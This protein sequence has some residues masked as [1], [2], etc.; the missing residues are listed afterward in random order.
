MEEIDH[1]TLIRATRQAKQLVGRIKLNLNKLD[2][3]NKWADRAYKN[4]ITY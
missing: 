1:R 3:F 2:L 4:L